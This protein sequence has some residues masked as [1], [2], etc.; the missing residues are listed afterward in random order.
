[1]SKESRKESSTVKE[2]SVNG[3]ILNIVEQFI[4]Y[5]ETVDKEEKDDNSI[6]SS[7]RN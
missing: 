2:H 5:F 3:D 1:M 6:I 7:K 4:T